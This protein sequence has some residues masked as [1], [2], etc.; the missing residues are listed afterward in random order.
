MV[1][2]QTHDQQRRESSTDPLCGFVSNVSDETL[3]LLTLAMKHMGILLE[4]D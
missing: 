1:L 2:L 3:N 4:P